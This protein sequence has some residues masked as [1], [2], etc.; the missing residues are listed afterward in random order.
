MAF[1]AEAKRLFQ[2]QLYDEAFSMYMRAI[3]SQ[4]QSIQNNTTAKQQTDI[5]HKCRELM[6]K[7]DQA[8]Q[9]ANSKRLT[10]NEQ[11]SLMET[12]HHR[13]LPQSS[14]LTTSQAT[15][16]VEKEQSII[17]TLSA[18]NEQTAQTELLNATSEVPQLNST[19][20][21]PRISVPETPEPH[22]PPSGPDVSSS[23]V[24]DL[25]TVDA[26]HPIVPRLEEAEPTAYGEPLGS[27][28]Q[29]RPDFLS[30]YSVTLGSPE[31][32]R[33][34]SPARFK[35]DI[36]TASPVSPQAHSNIP[37]M[38]LASVLEA[39]QNEREML[40]EQ[41]AREQARRK[42]L[43]R[44][45]KL[46]QL[47]LAELRQQLED[48]QQARHDLET[49]VWYTEREPAVNPVLEKISTENI[50]LRT[51]LNVAYRQLREMQHRNQLLEARMRELF[52]GVQ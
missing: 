49:Q 31:S 18:Q 45:S 37:D 24:A 50:G 51:D 41:F 47:E 48:E 10:A 39:L 3:D 9:L 25:P 8:R 40:V 26:I 21:P 13:T 43:E 14:P 15:L 27:N 7:A 2:R 28:E 42:H 17:A 36:R 29:Y 5:R 23:K 38:R 35:P 22:V 32:P 19:T 4:L 1:I 34:S 33:A 16:S 30:D 44:D 11:T 12:T 20:L 46:A 52:G 6:E